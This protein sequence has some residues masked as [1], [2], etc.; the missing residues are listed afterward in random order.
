MK[1]TKLN[2]QEAKQIDLVNY[3]ARQGLKPSRISGNIYWYL[4]PF[5]AEKSAS[6]KI[7]RKRN[8]WYDFTDGNGGTLIDFA[9][10]FH[11]CTI[12]EFLNLVSDP[13]TVVP[14]RTPQ[15]RKQ[16][17]SVP[18][19]PIVVTK[20]TPLLYDVLVA[21]VK[22]RGIPFHLADEY[23]KQVHFK[24]GDKPYFA[25]GFK[26]NSG[27]YEVRNALFK[28]SSSPKDITNID[29]GSNTL[30]VFEGF[31]DFLTYRA[32]M[33]ERAAKHNFLILNST[34]LLSKA[35]EIIKS[36]KHVHCYLDNNKTGRNA[37]KQIRLWNK[38]ARNFNRLYKN[39]A[40]LNEMRCAF[41]NVRR[42]GNAR[43]L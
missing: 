12:A 14:G 5:N 33:D 3:L 24:I 23:C 19:N 41:G 4:S 42:K 38:S 17:E 25:V 30:V 28:G 37:A 40:D 15:E 10:R 32:I 7:D 13:A 6:F 11:D 2:C 18:N 39:Y 34:T 22:S 21:Y 1:K 35:E 36:H 31:F 8:T 9:I 43:S 29:N 26:N 20:V 16:I 27:G